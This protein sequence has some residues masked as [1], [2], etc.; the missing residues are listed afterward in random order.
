[1]SGRVSV[2]AVATLSA[3]HTQAA[4][5]QVLSPGREGESQGKRQTQEQT[6]SRKAIVPCNEIRK[7]ERERDSEGRW[8]RERERKKR[9]RKLKKSDGDGEEDINGKEM[10][11]KTRG[12]IKIGTGEGVQRHLTKKR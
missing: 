7:K 9:K 5:T 4:A 3:S 6:G 2:S 12:K 1:M 8:R 11:K 10:G